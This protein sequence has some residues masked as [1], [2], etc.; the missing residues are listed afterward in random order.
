M[1]DAAADP[2][3]ST[4]P[5]VAGGAPAL[6][7]RYHTP[8]AW[9]ATALADPLALLADHAQ[10]ERKAAANALDLVNRWPRADCAEAWVSILA[11]VTADEA[12]HLK[13]VTRLLARRGG[14]LPRAHRNA[15]ASALHAAV[16]RG[17]GPRELLD[18]LLV[19]ALIEARS[20]ERFELLAAHGEDG[21][22]ASFF[23]SLCASER[24]HY[25]VFLRLAD[26]VAGP[27]E[28]KRRWHAWLDGEAA[29]IAAQAPGPRIHSGVRD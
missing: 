15:Y 9:V 21:E 7:L 3:P 19:A 26:M 8:A 13:A 24:G 4:T 12:M 14:E 17:D 10:L 27:A 18:R 5:V 1:N 23:A 16:R 28:R 22:L 29:I 6:P 25:K 11:A 20:C 2:V